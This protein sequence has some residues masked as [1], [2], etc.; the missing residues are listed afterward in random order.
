ML[1]TQVQKHLR[2]SSSRLLNL[3][4]FY[5]GLKNKTLTK[6]KKVGHLHRGQPLWGQFSFNAGEWR[7]NL[8]GCWE[9][10]RWHCTNENNNKTFRHFIFK[11]VLILP[12]ELIFARL[13]FSV[14][15]V[16]NKSDSTRFQFYFGTKNKWR[17]RKKC[18][19]LFLKLDLFWVDI[20]VA[21]EWHLVSSITWTIMI[22]RKQTFRFF[23]VEPYRYFKPIVWL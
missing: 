8:G 11:N 18:N 15:N 2:E 7:N 19:F 3:P 5:E 17:E 21:S 10:R 1:S 13:T 16:K 22:D 9:A 20:V 12:H 14:F 4:R 6:R 23:L